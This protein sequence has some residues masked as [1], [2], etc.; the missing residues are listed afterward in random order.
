MDID[1]NSYIS[2][3]LA[4]GTIYFVA[5][6]SPG[7][8]FAMTMRNSLLYSR[9]AGLFGALGTTTGMCIHLT[10][11][12][13]GIGYLITQMPW[14]LDTIKIIGASYLIYI[15][16]KSFRSKK[17]IMEDINLTKGSK[18]PSTLTPFQAFRAGFLTNALNPMVILLFLGILSGYVDENTPLTIQLLYGLM[19]VIISLSWFALVA[20]CFSHEKVQKQFQKLGHWLE[21]I[22]G[23]LLIT[24]GLKLALISARQ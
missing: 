16:Y 14:L 10:Y 22:T 17:P 3:F 6:V 8:D 13:L 9:K 23:G 5:V 24:F 4:I 20:I 19:I 18:A 1:F 11:T 21:R 12:V 2:S 7:P 15:G